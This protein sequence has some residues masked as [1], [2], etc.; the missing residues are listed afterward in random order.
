MK[1]ELR[2]RSIKDYDINYIADLRWIMDSRDN[3]SDEHIIFVKEEYG[4]DISGISDKEAIIEIIRESIL[5]MYN[6][7]I[8]P[9]VMLLYS[10]LIWYKNALKRLERLG[11]IEKCGKL[12][13]FKSV[14]NSYII[15][16]LGSLLSQKYDRGNVDEY[17]NHS[18]YKM[19]SMM[20]KRIIA[21]DDSDLLDKL[22]QNIYG[23]IYSCRYLHFI[24]DDFKVD[25]YYLLKW[26]YYPVDKVFRDVINTFDS[27]INRLAYDCL[28]YTSPSPR[29]CS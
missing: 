15:S 17:I 5:E 24:D 8:T 12:L 11:E 19:I 1:N 20:K 25:N 23:A 28:L 21:S 4:C 2:G 14:L 29:D 7:A 3:I 27:E 10:F 26:E 13:D 6:D 16:N 9:S 18:K 22:V